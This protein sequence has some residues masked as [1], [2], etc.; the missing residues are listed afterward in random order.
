MKQVRVS[1]VPVL[2]SLD[3]RFAFRGRLRE[4]MVVQ[5]G[6]PE[7]GFPHILP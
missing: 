5:G 4:L 1:F 3:G 6:V 2:H 7:Q